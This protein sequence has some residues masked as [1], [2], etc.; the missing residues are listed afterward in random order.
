LELEDHV[1]EL[2]GNILRIARREEKKG[3]EVVSL[4]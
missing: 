4:L 1:W 2:D 3:E